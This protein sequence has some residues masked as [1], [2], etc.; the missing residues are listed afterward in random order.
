[1][2]A[3][4]TNKEPSITARWL[5]TFRSHSDVIFVRAVAIM[6]AVMGIINVFSS[7]L[8]ALMERLSVLDQISPLEVTRGS[9]LATVVA[10]FALLLLS[11]NLWRRKQ[12][13]WFLTVTI[14]FTSAVSHLLKG[15]DYEEASIAFLLAVWVFS[16]R[17]HFHARSD[18]PSIQQGFRTLVYAALF[19]L[20]YGTLGFY[21]LDEH[22]NVNFYFIPALL[23]TLAMFA[24]FT[25]PG[26]TPVTPFG[27][28]FADSIYVIAGVTLSYGF[29]MLVRPVLVRQPATENERSRARSVVEA[30]GR[31][32]LARMT[33]FKDKSYF[34]SAN[35]TM[36]AYVVKGRIAI[37]LG[38]PLGAAE[39]A[40]ASITEFNDFCVRNDWRPCFYQVS[41]EYL[42]VYKG[43][44][45]SYFSIGE[46]AIVDLSNFTMEGK[47]GKEFRN[48]ANKLGKL[49]HRV[50]IYEP[51]L[52]R[53]L[54]GE[55]RAVSDEWLFAMHGSEMRFSVG[56]FDDE[57]V[58]NSVTAVARDADGH[59]SAFANVVPEYQRNGVSL[60][61]MRRRHQIENGTMDLLFTS[62]FEWAKQKGYATF[63]LG[64]SALS[65][66]GEKSDDPAV[67]K[68]LRLLSDNVSRF[69]NF[70]GL[71]SFKGKFHPIWEPRYLVY[72]ESANLPAIGTAL[73]RAHSGDNFL[74]GYLKNK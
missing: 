4:S 17:P 69:Y 42:P 66:I 60:D 44:G 47:A 39:D 57:Y 35:G 31:S 61:L 7:S 29:F 64:L 70:K 21:L 1:M 16:L 9:R 22:F 50:D 54:I 46:E 14:L 45:F 37:V 23:Q 28:Y 2:L 49:G 15:L 63:G 71:H 6:T 51:P 41:S 67:E 20:A 26:L 52:S 24:E 34:F 10:G 3:K 62:F 72:L 5:D 19:T 36:L 32:A 11:R 40:G 74:W 56:W 48:V 53:E 13:A 25:N 68:V 8:P 12:V 18:T 38:D 65:G 33:L 43:A 59:I 73:V 27:Q 30:H 58:R 55:L